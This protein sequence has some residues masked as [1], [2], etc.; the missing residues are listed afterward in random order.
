MTNGSPLYEK[1]LAQLKDNAEEGYASF[2]K[3][4][5]K[6]EEINVLGVRV[7]VLR[8]IAKGY[9]NCISELLDLPD[10]YYE[11]T[12]VKLQAAALLPYK[13]FIH[14]V[15]KCVSVI[16]NWATC[17]CFVPKCVKENKQDF[18]K[19]ICRYLA[20]DR[21][22]YQRFALTTLLHFYVEE[23]WLDEI[24]NCIANRSD[25]NYYYVHM[26]AAWL[27]AEILVRYYERG[28]GYLNRGE[29]HARTHNKAIS[30][31]C[32]S[33]RLTKEQK[34]YLITLKR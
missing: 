33:F 23:E 12:F 1:L 24:Y 28:V 18:Y 19:Y 6:N 26:A 11:V 2:H 31:A 5:L 17:D 8:K 22:Y 7:P 21:E 9:I 3:R 15:D 10:E 25:N 4:L 16:D 20:T 30:K 29:I 13:Q 32:E 27:L 34:Q 14:C